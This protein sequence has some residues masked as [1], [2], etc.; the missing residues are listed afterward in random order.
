MTQKD[1]YIKK[2]NQYK[3]SGLSF[4]KISRGRRNP[5]T[6]QNNQGKIRCYVT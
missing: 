2:P 6:C 5:T 3:K 1:I 4:G